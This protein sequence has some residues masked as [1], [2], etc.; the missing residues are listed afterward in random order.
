MPQLFIRF[1]CRA[2]APLGLHDCVDLTSGLV[3][4]VVHDT[5]GRLGVVAIDGNLKAS[6]SWPC[7]EFFTQLRHARCMRET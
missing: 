5:A 2:A 1:T 3:Q 6:L 4:A 7:S